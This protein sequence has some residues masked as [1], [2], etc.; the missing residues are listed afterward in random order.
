MSPA[1]YLLLVGS[2]TG[3]TPVNAASNPDYDAIIAE[4]HS[5][6]Q[7][8]RQE[9]LQTTWQWQSPED[10]PNQV[11]GT[12]LPRSQVILYNNN[13]DTA[14]ALANAFIEQCFANKSSDWWRMTFGSNGWSGP[15]LENSYSVAV[16][17]MFTSKSRWVREGS[18]ARVT[19]NA[20]SGMLDF[21]SNY[22]G[23]CA[24][25]QTHEW[26][27]TGLQLTDSE[28]IDTVRHTACYFASDTLCK[29]SQYAN[30]TLA[31]GK[32]VCETASLWE[33]YLYNWLKQQAINGFFDELGSSGY[34]YRT[35]PCL[36][37]MH[38]LSDPG[39]RLRKRAKMFLD[40]AF[41]EAEL[42]SIGGVRAGQK[43]RD[44]KAECP[45]CSKHGSN[46]NI[47]HHMYTALTPQLY[48][49]D[50][51]YAASIYTAPI[52][53]QQL[54]V[55][56]MSNV[57]VLI[58]RL[59]AA[60]E[61]GG[62]YTMRNRM[63]G[64]TKT[65]FVTSCDPS[66]CAE[67]YRPVPCACVGL[68]GVS[69]PLLTRSRQVHIVSKT[70]NYAIA[71]VSFS[72]NDAFVANSQQRGT[73]VVFG[74]R[75]HSVVALPHLTG[76]KWAV[77]DRDVMIGQRC[78]SCNYGGPSMFQ[79]YNASALASDGEWW[80]MTAG[81]GR[82]WAGM[83]PA[84]GGTNFTNTTSTKNPGALISGNINLLDTWSA[85]VIVVGTPDEYG[86]LGNFSQ[87][88]Q[89]A[90]LKA[91]DEVFEWKWKNRTYDFFPGP[92]TDIGSWRLPEIDGKAVDVDP[93]FL[94]SSPHLNAA[95]ES[96]TV[97]ASYKDYT[98]VYNFTDDTI[99]RV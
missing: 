63:M 3:I 46:P 54:G 57:S 99:T 87:Q 41:L 28:N 31:D 48:G 84:N 66:R 23:E 79:I 51:A 14:V 70:K 77:I 24:A 13:N 67:T 34:W 91:D 33:A 15:P 4:S 90:P 38:H 73:G 55:Y 18:V 32:T 8:N 30:E 95:L 45:T 61:T 47:E 98:L 26:N 39:S 97:T 36:W 71:G 74:N 76:E 68:P 62:A 93:P 53:T 19:E 50:M 82:G 1:I 58:H 92:S 27:Q 12:A 78:G 6:A 60:P 16:F 40:L 20:E 56:Q 25:Y 96:E 81:E 22:V 80:F 44:K 88:V 43:S 5:R 10:Q 35:W 21:W 59:G 7:T 85:F 94:Y 89:A 72:P 17:A 2:A 69:T 65:S 29:Y 75:D 64:M 49:D 11:Q 42:A 9:L 86:T 37:D 83:R 52:S